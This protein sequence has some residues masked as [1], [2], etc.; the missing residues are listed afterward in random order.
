MSLRSVEL[1]RL[2]DATIFLLDR[3]VIGG[4]SN[5]KAIALGVCLLDRDHDIGDAT[6][7]LRFRDIE[8]GVRALP[9][10]PQSLQL[11]AGGG[12]QAGV[13]VKRA[14]CALQISNR[15]L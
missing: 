5:R 2:I 4:Y 8:L 10:V 11:F 12:N 13:G 3:L 6:R 9:E 7:L 15:L 14:G 1:N